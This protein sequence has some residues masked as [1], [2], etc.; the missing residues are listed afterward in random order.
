RWGA[1]S[2]CG[3]ARAGEDI[4]HRRTKPHRPHTNGRCERLHKPLL[5][6]GYRVTF[7]TQIY[8]SLAD[9]QADL[10]GWLAESNEQRLQTPWRHVVIQVDNTVAYSS[11]RAPILS[12]QALIRQTGREEDQ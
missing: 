4:E 5:K 8:G 3:R 1:G 11:H 6:E 9:L 12:A 10:D 2:P 7:R